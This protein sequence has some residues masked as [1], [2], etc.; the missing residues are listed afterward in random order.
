MKNSISTWFSKKIQLLILSGLIFFSFQLS[1]NDIMIKPGDKTSLSIREN[2]YSKLHLYNSVSKIKTFDVNTERG[3][4]TKFHISEYAKSLTVG[5]PE[6]P[7]KRVLIEIPVGAKPVVKINSFEVKEFKLSE[8]DI[9]NKIIPAQPPRSKSEDF[10]E[11]IYNENAYTINS[12]G[13]EEL[14]TVDI[15]GYMRGTRIA[16]LNIAPVQYNP[17]TNAIR[18]YENIDFEIDFENADINKT[19]ELKK[20]YYSPYFNAINNQLLN[21]KEVSGRENFMRYPIKYLIISDR[22]FESQLQPLIEWKI[23]KG[24]TIV[25]AYTDE[26]GVGTTTQ[27]IKAYIENL[28]NAGT[29]EDP[30]PSFVLFVGDIQQIPA[31]NNG[32]GATDRNYCEFT[33]D[34]FPEIYYGRYSAQTTAHLQPQID[35]TLMYERY[36]MPDPTYLDEVVLVVGVDASHSYDWGNGQINYGTINYFNEDHGILSHTYLYPASG[37]SSAQIIQNISDGVTFGNYTAHCSP[38]GWADPSFTISDISGLQNQDMYGLLVGNCCSSSEYQLDECFAEA[39]LRAENKG[40]VGYIGASNSTYWDEDYYFAVGVG[41]ISQN[42]PSYEET[43]LGAYDRTFHDHG[44]E[45]GEWYVTQ[46]EMIFAGNLAVTEGSPG[47]AQYYWDVYCLMGDPS[48]MIY[49]S[50]PPVIAVTYQE[51]MPLGSTSFTVTTEAYAYVA[52]SLN[53][54]LHGVTLA[55]QDGIAEIQLTPITTPG[56]ADVIVTK[57]NGEPF[58]GTVLVA[59]PEGPYMTLS[60]IEINDESGNNNGLAD[61]GE[62]VSL[63]V[64]LENLGNSD[65]TAVSATISSS[66]PLITITK[67]YHEWGNVP[68]QS[69]LMQDSAFA[70][71]VAELIPDQHTVTFNMDIENVNKEIW[72]TDFTITLNAPV[73]VIES[74]T[75]DD[76][77]TGNNNGRLD[78]GETADIKVLNKNSGH[79]IAENTIATLTTA[80]QYI[81]MQNT[82]DSLGTFGLFGPVYAIYNVT[83]DPDAPNGVVFATFDYE[84]VSGVYQAD[85]TFIR[86]IGLLY[87][88]FET[89][90]FSKFDWQLE[91]DAPWTV[92]NLYPYEGYYSAKSGAIADNQY[93]ELSLTLEIMTT[94]SLSFV[95]KV[96]SEENADY[97]KFFINGTLQDLWSGTTE[98][99][100]KEIFPVGVGTFTF[101]WV[102]QKNGGTSGGADCAWLDYV[103]MPPVLTLTCYVGPDDEI[104][105]GDDFQCMGEATDCVS[106]EWTT[107]GTGTF[108]DNTILQ[109]IYT[110]SIEDITAG[111]VTLTITASDSE[112][113]FVDDEMSLTFITEPETPDMPTGPDYV[114]LAFTTTSVYTV[115][116]T[117]FA[118][119]YEWNIE[120]VEAGTISGDDL[121]GTVEW[122][123]SYLGYAYISVKAINECGDSDYSDAFEVTVD[124]TVGISNENIKNEEFLIYPNPV[125]NLSNIEFKL[126]HKSSVSIVIYNSLGQEVFVLLNK[127]ILDSGSHKLSVDVS[128]F[129]EGIYYCMLTTSDKKITKKLIII[130]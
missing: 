7:V 67:N 29:Q 28:Y 36:T 14:V 30:A 102:Y 48:L 59:N 24:F 74:L 96:S 87:D 32:N 56:T 100:V 8:F 54:V 52:I 31:W 12:F 94:D 99:W 120:P 39:L 126:Q 88:D 122:D 25:E 63:N 65:A 38:N 35:K 34:L 104:C 10:H 83:V 93:S 109:P 77:Q 112:G 97:L 58:F 27:S 51:L 9:S 47:S 85:E 125:D 3:L 22:M 119:S 80:S 23:K 61:F 124:N 106:V 26:P 62:N 49:Y 57:Q 117:L 4:F 33:G 105:E 6:L 130:K 76:S 95:R 41:Q 121:T 70:F 13:D 5:S 91:G 81:T 64:E 103:I 60:D 128:G 66:D 79:C 16:R 55:D 111:L 17:V 68:A 90:N 129:E 69:T 50:E 19:L 110:P 37:S 40:T 115:T 123:L 1:A 72:N 75:I 107:S 11:F 45:F 44:E 20:N 42:P 78:P 101:K 108:N 118:A 82:I 98:G 46:D 114:D 73:L 43:T 71:M 116:Q 21:Y 89:G 127:T 86:K 84:V 53:G 15:L 113:D 18:V 2:T 92:S